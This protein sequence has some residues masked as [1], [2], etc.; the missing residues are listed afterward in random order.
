MFKEIKKTRRI[1]ESYY[2][3]VEEDLIKAF[4]KSTAILIQQIHLWIEKSQGIVQD[5]TRWIYNT[6]EEWAKQ[7]YVSARQLRRIQK[8]L[9]ELGILMMKKLSRNKSDRT[10]FFSLNYEKLRAFL[11]QNVKDKRT[12]KPLQYNQEIPATPRESSLGH[13]VLMVIHKKTEVINKSEKESLPPAKE[14]PP[15]SKQVGQ[16]TTTVQNMVKIWNKH[17]SDKLTLKLSKPLAKMLMGAFKHKFD[18]DLNRWE[19]YC[20]LIT[21]SEFLMGSRFSM[22]AAW[23]LKFATID[24]ILQGEY[25]TKTFIPNYQIEKRLEEHLENAPQY[26]LRK[27]LLKIFGK[28]TYLG[29]FE[30]TEVTYDVGCL[31]VIADH[32][33]KR[34]WI[35]VNFRYILE[36]NFGK[37][38]ILEKGDEV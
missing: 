13:N 10:N 14:D 30:K 4:G 11:K 29:W 12:F 24:L 38:R 28:D 17:C 25:G 27:K 31:T 9:Q 15:T 32:A 37:V 3:L 33:F 35:Y 5:G 2:C 19:Y 1:N 8:R 36:D 16:V 23:A 6:A 21:T 18:R 20:E 7:A 22:N 34:N 26:D